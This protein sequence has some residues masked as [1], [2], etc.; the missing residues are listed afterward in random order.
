M[1]LQTLKP[2]NY[3]YIKL[4]ADINL[5]HYIHTNVMAKNRLYQAI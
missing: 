2:V 1:Y 3:N 5:I 4:K